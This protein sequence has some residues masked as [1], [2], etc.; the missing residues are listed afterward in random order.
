M[1]MRRTKIALKLL[2]K[3]R[4]LN[5]R[6][7][8]FSELLVFCKGFCVENLIA[9]SRFNLYF[10]KFFYLIFVFFIFIKSYLVTHKIKVA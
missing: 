2:C 1:K 9:R 6:L 3:C 4:G 5:L 10:S 8:S 7:R